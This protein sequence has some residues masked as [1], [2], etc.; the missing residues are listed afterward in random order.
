MDI[1]FYSSSRAQMSRNFCESF[2]FLFK[3]F[4]LFQPFLCEL[5]SVT[6]EFPPKLIDSSSKFEPKVGKIQNKSADQVTSMEDELVRE[7]KRFEQLLRVATTYDDVIKV[8][9]VSCSSNS[10]ASSSNKIVFVL[11]QLT[12]QTPTLLRNT[13]RMKLT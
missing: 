2:P 9:L 10:P 6:Q 8:C 11:R 4:D 7:F 5:R 13:T 3:T 12:T 1:S